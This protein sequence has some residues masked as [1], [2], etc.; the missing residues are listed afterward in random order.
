[1]V[2]AP[3]SVQ[4]FLPWGPWIGSGSEHISGT[5]RLNAN[6][7]AY[8]GTLLLSATASVRFL[9]GDSYVEEELPHLACQHPARP[10]TFSPLH[11][12]PWGASSRAWMWASCSRPP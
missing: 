2:P 7:H 1:M 8:K 11:R 4:W 10:C 5:P 6:S 12:W 9:K 3:S